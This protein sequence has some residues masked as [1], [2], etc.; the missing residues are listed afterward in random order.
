[1]M[2]SALHIK[3]VIMSQP[4]YHSL[5]HRQ[6]PGLQSYLQHL[7]C[8]SMVTI[9]PTCASDTDGVMAETS[10][11]TNPKVL[12]NVPRLF[13][14]ELTSTGT[15][16]YLLT[17]Y[18]RFLLHYH[19]LPEHSR[20]YYELIPRGRCCRVHMDVERVGIDGSFREMDVVRCLVG[21]FWRFLASIFGEV[22]LGATEA[23]LEEVINDPEQV[24][25]KLMCRTVYLTASYEGK[26]SAHLVL[27]VD[28]CIWL[29]NEN[30]GLLVR[31]F[32]DSWQDAEVKRRW[33]DYDEGFWYVDE[34]VSERERLILW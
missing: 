27:L 7:N 31:H 4:P 26:F 19:T 22:V 23:T 6:Q 33:K 8:P 25:D 9:N 15:R 3:K 24:V 16:R 13:S 18:S 21:E 34:K 5:H 32:V 14:L 1:M 12:S 20:H 28:G 17:S 29:D 2:A 10:K 30:L 11:Q